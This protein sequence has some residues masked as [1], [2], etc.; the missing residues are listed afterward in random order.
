M[1]RR[2]EICVSK[3]VL[4]SHCQTTPAIETCSGFGCR[5]ETRLPCHAVE[6]DEPHVDDERPDHAAARAQR[7]ASALIAAAIASGRSDDSTP[8]A[9]WTSA[10]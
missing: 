7:I 8:R 6:V 4:Q 10:S 3:P 1:S 9:P 2:Q 5:N